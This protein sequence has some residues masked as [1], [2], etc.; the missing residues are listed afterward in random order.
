[1][2]NKIQSS[3]E[4]YEKKYFLTTSQQKYLLSK[5]QPYIKADDYGEYTIC[6]IYYDTD[7]WRLIR[8]SIEKPVYKEKLRV[9]SYGIPEDDG[10]VFVELK[11]KYNGVVY[12]RRITAKANM[13]EPILYGLEPESLCGQIGQEITWFQKFHQTKPKVFIAYDRIAFAG[14]ENPGLRI[15]FDTNMRWRDRDLDLRLGDYGQ[16][17]L[18][19]NRILME[20]KMPG[21]CPLWLSRLLSET[22]IFP[23]SFSKYGTCYREHILKKENNKTK[24]EAS[25][26]ANCA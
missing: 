26:H 13:V 7:D 24:K 16:P 8:E 25:R 1:M 10:K 4:R 9:R 20:I 5:M 2:A 6:N 17:I 14:T 23:V 21:A 15:T 3:F 18:S 19:D 22:E 12:K 11:K